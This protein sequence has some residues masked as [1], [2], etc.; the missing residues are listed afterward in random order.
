MIRPRRHMCRI[1]QTASMQRN[2]SETGALSAS[3]KANKIKYICA[4]LLPRVQGERQ[5]GCCQSSISSQQSPGFMPLGGAT[6]SGLHKATQQISPADLSQM[7]TTLHWTMRAVACL[8]AD[9]NSMNRFLKASDTWM[10]AGHVLLIKTL[11]HNCP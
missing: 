3:Y 8:K 10:H 11:Y 2:T 7:L 6:P 5:E 9:V 1:C 4:K